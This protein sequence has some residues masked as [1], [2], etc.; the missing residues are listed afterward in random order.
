MFAHV[1]LPIDINH[2]AS[3]QKALPM[4]VKLCGASGTLH[5]AGIVH[6]LGAAALSSY[7]P[8][9]FEAEALR[10]MAEALDAFARRELPEGL[11]WRTHVGHGHVPEQILAL[12][13][14]SGAEVIVMAS[15]PHDELRGML[16]GSYAGKVVRNA[17]IPVMV[18]R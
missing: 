16:V 14:R 9:D 11:A 18:V 4:A 13:G 2:P 1:L 12:A 8:R 17:G 5:L 10:H 7:L 15:T 3:W 6:D